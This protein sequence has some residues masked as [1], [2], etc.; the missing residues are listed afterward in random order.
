MIALAE[1]AFGASSHIARVV[2]TAMRF[3]PAIRSAMAVRYSPEILR[4]CRDAGLTEAS[5]DRPTSRPKC[6]SGRVQP[7]MGHGKRPSAASNARPIWC[8]MGR[9]GQWSRSSACWGPTAG[10]GGQV[11]PYRPGRGL[12]TINR[13]KPPFPDCRVRGLGVTLGRGPARREVIAGWT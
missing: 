10:R 8:T 4:A 3:D 1:P 5:F 12:W 6:G 2:L 9:P 7:G 13:P 11:H